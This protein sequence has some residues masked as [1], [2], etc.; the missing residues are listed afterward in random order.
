MAFDLLNEFSGEELYQKALEFEERNDINNLFIYM[1]AAADRDYQL[2]KD[3]L[4]DDYYGEQNHK[5]QDY[6]IT[7]YFYEQNCDK[8]YSCNYYGW[9]HCDSCSYEDIV[10]DRNIADESYLKAAKMGNIVGIEN[11]EYQK[12]NFEDVMIIYDAIPK[13]MKNNLKYVFLEKF[14]FDRKNV[15]IED[16]QK[17]ISYGGESMLHEL[18]DDNPAVTYILENI[19]IKNELSVLQKKYDDLVMH[20]KASPDGELFLEAYNGWMNKI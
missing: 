11:M 18:L 15:N 3:Y 8:P 17:I 5:I 1:T 10:T 19:K 4:Y 2:A 6:S 13:P 20:V 7:R 12:I 14:N 16:I 9:M